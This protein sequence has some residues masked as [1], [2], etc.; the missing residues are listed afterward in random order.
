MYRDERNPGIGNQMN[1][2]A[3]F[4]GRQKMASDLSPAKA[5]LEIISG[6]VPRAALRF[7]SFRGACP[8]LNSVAGYA[9]S[10]SG[11]F[12]NVLCL[13]AI[14]MML[15]SFAGCTKTTNTEQPH[16]A[17]SPTVSNVTSSAD[18]VKVRVA[19]VSFPEAGNADAIMTLSI[20][21]GYHINANPATFSYLIATEVTAEKVEGLDV[22]KPIYPAAVK[23][24]FQFAD[25]PLAV[26]EGN[27]NVRLPFVAKSSGTK[28]LPLSVR[29]QACDQEKCFPPD[30]LHATIAV[31]VK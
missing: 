18:V 14:A 6:T 12:Q 24:K 10:L 15:V 2:K 16:N 22:G 26:Y 1:S 19:D 4:S 30:T 20:S 25:E 21:P 29:V 28:S 23:K 8:G 5:G 7:T 9:G 17:Q 11:S 31:E 13:S 27:V 3:R